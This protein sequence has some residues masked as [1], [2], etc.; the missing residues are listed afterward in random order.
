MSALRVT[1]VEQKTIP[2]VRVPIR[3]KLTVPYLVLSLFLAVAA[4]Y[5]ITQ[6]VVENL[7]ERFNKQLFE[8]GKISSELMVSYET[9]L[10][11]TL[12]LL[13]NAEGVPDAL[14]A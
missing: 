6:L 8:A 10:L 11:E 4:A 5:L 14:L 2:R 3:T 13:A 12:R 7:Q 1:S 9:E